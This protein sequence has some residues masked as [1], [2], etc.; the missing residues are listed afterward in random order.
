M[1]ETKDDKHYMVPFPIE[2]TSEITTMYNS[3]TALSEKGESCTSTSSF[4]KLQKASSVPPKLTKKIS[5]DSESYHDDL[6]LEDGPSLDTCAELKTV[7]EM[8]RRISSEPSPG[9][10][11][12]KK[13]VEYASTAYGVRMLSKNLTKTKV[14]LNVENLIIITK[15]TDVSLIFLTRE[16]VEWLLTTFPNLNIYVED[17]FKGSNQFAADEICDDT[18][19]RESRIRY[20][21]Q[22]FIAKH[23]DFFDLCVTLGGDGTV[24]F[25]STV[26]QKSV[27]PTVSFSLGSL[28]FLT[29]FNFEYFK[30]DLRKIPVS[31]THLDVYKRQL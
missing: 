10:K 22:E 12:H 23:D 27:P 24:L 17:T 30:Q 5:Q 9:A 18:K 11:H 28:G 15:T 21:N 4:P 2:D 13:H 6:A 31:Y 29:N 14:Q 26:F 19:C 7:K 16:L 8:V 3:S 1:I 20:W 25:V